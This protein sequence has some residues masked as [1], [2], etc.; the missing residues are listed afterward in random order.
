MTTAYIILFAILFLIIHYIFPLRWR[1]NLIFATG[2]GTLAML[3]F[4]SIVFY[5]VIASIVFLG[6]VLISGKTA[7]QPHIKRILT[8]GICAI[9]FLILVFFKARSHVDPD[10]SVPIGLSYFTLMLVGY[11][12]DI[13]RGTA[14]IP[15]NPRSMLRFSSFFPILAIGP[16]ERHSH[17]APQLATPR[18]ISIEM[19]RAGLFLI[20]LGTFKKF[21]IADRLYDF[22]FDPER[23]YLKLSGF[24]LWVYTFCAFLQIFAEFSGLIDGVRG[25]SKLLG[26]DLFDNFNQPYLAKSVP[27]IWRRWHITLVDWLRDYVY[28]PIALQTRNL[29]LAA[30]TVMIFVGLWHRIAWSGV[31]WGLYW[32]VLYS[33]SIFFH[34]RGWRVVVPDF[35]RVPFMIILMSISTIFFAY[36]DLGSTFGFLAA[37]FK[38]STTP[39]LDFTRISKVDLGISLVGFLAIVFIETWDRGTK[40]KLNSKLVG[41]SYAGLTLILLLLTV[42]YGV[43]GS[44]AFVYLR[45]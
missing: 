43:G 7:R 17:L 10:I 30:W 27:D 16:I 20:A 34:Q 35:V 28:T 25:F 24:N 29:Y 40:F 8:F 26:I 21:V 4:E 5:F 14:P 22:V 19:V 38:T 23:S 2:L 33:F 13:S 32:A 18:K 44:Q 1:P 3:G 39:L 15:R 11:F 37:L 45:Y 12:L 9:P 36:E 31:Y 42:L 41:L 6:A